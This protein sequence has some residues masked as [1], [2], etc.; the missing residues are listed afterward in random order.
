LTEVKVLSN[1]AFRIHLIPAQPGTRH[2]HTD[3]T[4]TDSMHLHMPCSMQ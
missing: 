3:S 2:D 4:T 1:N